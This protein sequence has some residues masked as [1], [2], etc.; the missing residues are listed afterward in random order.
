MAD[1]LTDYKARQQE[2]ATP[3]GAVA[4][5]P[6]KTISRR[7]RAL[8]FCMFLTLVG[9]IGLNIAPGPKGSSDT[10]SSVTV[11]GV[12]TPIHKFSFSRPYGIPFVVARTEIDDAGNIKNLRV[13][14]STGIF[15]NFAVAFA[16]S[17]G[18]LA[19]I[20]RRRRN[21]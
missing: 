10:V 4:P 16:V 13:N 5:I 7:R 14:A 1:V 3:A 2:D 11:N 20:G 12:K 19:L 17:L 15:G 6:A 18:L 21:D 9:G 8:R